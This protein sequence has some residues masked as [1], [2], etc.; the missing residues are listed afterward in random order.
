MLLFYFCIQANRD[1]L[2]SL[3]TARDVTSWNKLRRTSRLDRTLHFILKKLHAHVRYS[4]SFFKILYPFLCNIDLF[5]GTTTVF[6][7]SRLSANHHRRRMV[8]GRF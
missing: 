2:P 7:P 8:Q 5:L 1:A 3:I 6:R 4:Y